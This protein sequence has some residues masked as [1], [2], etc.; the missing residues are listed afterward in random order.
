MTLVLKLCCHLGDVLDEVQSTLG[1]AKLIPSLSSS[2]L[3]YS[4]R[5]GGHFSLF[6][7]NEMHFEVLF[8]HVFVLLDHCNTTNYVKKQ[9]YIL[10][11]V[12]RLIHVQLH[13]HIKII[14]YTQ[15]NENS[16]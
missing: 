2:L 13:V 4:M 12:L 16:M 14:F 9:M 5:E 3:H 6:V 15:I 11:F 7:Y 1:Q 8:R 10:L